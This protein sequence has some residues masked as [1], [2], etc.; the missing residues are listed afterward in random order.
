MISGAEIEYQVT[1]GNNGEDPVSGSIPLNISIPEA[2]IN[3]TFDSDDGIYNNTTKVFTLDSVLNAGESAV[4]TV[5]ATLSPDYEEEQISYSST[6][7]APQGVYDPNLDNNTNT[8]TVSITKQI[9]LGI[10]L[11]AST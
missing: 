11:S 4:I 3:P 10:D 5:T 1:I 9:N 2:F 6:V 8:V 7:T